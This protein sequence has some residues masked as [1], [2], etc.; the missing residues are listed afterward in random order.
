R[1][2]GFGGIERVLDRVA[3]AIDG[4]AGKIGKWVSDET[5][6]HATTAVELFFKRKYHQSLG[7]IFSQKSHTSL[8]P[9]PQLRPPVIPN[10]NAALVHLARDAPVKCGGIN[11][12]GEI[13][14]AAIGFNN[15]LAKQAPNFGKMTEDFCDSDDGKLLGI[16][17]GVASSGAHALSSY[18]E[19]LERRIISAQRLH[20]LRA[21]HFAGS[22]PGRDQ[23]EHA[24]I[25]EP[26]S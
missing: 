9:R 1:D 17:D 11:D 21:I 26:L 7:H 19:E 20:K 6:I 8:T 16:D 4:R 10:G 3:A 24:G 23:D 12:D 14:P 25:V 13:G 2:P 22:L 5:R 15:Q 18:P